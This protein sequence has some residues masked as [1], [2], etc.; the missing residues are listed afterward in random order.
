MKH[1]G[2]L[3]IIETKL[4][5]TFPTSQFLVDGFSEY[6]IPDRNTNGNSIMIFVLADISSK[7][8]QNMISLLIMKIHIVSMKKN[9]YLMILILEFQ[10]YV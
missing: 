5:D 2:I 1:V 3:V 4:D 8:P 10:R 9:F 6:L 7:L